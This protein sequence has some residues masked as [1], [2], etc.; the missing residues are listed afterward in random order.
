[1]AKGEDSSL[2]V[3]RS[4]GRVQRLVTS[5]ALPPRGALLTRSVDGYKVLQTCQQT[6]RLS[7]L[8]QYKQLGMPRAQQNVYT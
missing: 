7:P 4:R 6:V 3:R 5:I 8:R 2:G 1:M